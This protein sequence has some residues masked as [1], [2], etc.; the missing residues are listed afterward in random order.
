M[1]ILYLWNNNYIR[2]IYF[3]IKNIK[4]YKNIFKNIYIEN[5]NVK[6][7]NIFYKI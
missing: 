5:K 3:Y 2:C 6:F 1:F 4:I 7:K